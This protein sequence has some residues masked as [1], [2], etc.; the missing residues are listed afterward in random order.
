MH[1]PSFLP[2]TLYAKNPPFISEKEKAG[3]LIVS[4]K[5]GLLSISYK[6]LII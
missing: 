2:A 5:N 3:H 4:N 6:K 1:F